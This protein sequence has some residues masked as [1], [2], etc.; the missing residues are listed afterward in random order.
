VAA[1][2]AQDGHP[3]PEEEDQHHHDRGDQDEYVRVRLGPS[4]GATTVI[5][6]T[7]AVAC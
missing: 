3:Q 6:E 1:L 4:K 5:V 2:A 7:R